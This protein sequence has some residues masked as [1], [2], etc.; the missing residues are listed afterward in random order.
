MS[1]DTYFHK[2]LE[3]ADSLDDYLVEMFSFL[4]RHTILF[5]D[6]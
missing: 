6:E 4:R 2:A 5:S 3:K 1:L